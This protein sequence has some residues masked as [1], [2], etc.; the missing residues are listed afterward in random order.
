MDKCKYYLKENGTT[1][2]FKSDAE[3]TE[4]IRNN[5]NNL[6]IKEGVDFVFDQ[7]P[8]LSEIGTQ[9][10]YS[11]YLDTIFPNKKTM[12]LYHGQPEINNITA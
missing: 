2:M 8:K 1:L 12:I 5:Q 3:L 10:Q 7:N 11:E 9:Q 4:F 6:E